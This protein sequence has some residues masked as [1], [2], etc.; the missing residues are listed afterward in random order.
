MWK[1]KLRIVLFRTQRNSMT[2]EEWMSLLTLTFFLHFPFKQRD[3]ELERD[4]EGGGVRESKQWML[5][6][7]KLL[8]RK[9]R[10]SHPKIY[11]IL[12]NTIFDTYINAYTLHTI[13][14][15]WRIC[16]GYVSIKLFIIFVP[17]YC[18]KRFLFVRCGGAASVTAATSATVIMKVIKSIVIIW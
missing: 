3:S 16:L 11:A 13:A 5:F 8:M 17:F 4:R 9:K 15:L 18:I 1:R 14:L 10:K 7:C 2:F 12:L 6:F